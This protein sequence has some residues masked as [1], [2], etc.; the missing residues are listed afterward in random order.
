MDNFSYC[1]LSAPIESAIP[2]FAGQ[3]ANSS[4]CAVDRLDAGYVSPFEIKQNTALRNRTANVESTTPFLSN[5]QP[6]YR[7]LQIKEGDQFCIF[8]ANHEFKSNR[9]AIGLISGYTFSNYFWFVHS[10]LMG[11]IEHVELS[12]LQMRRVLRS[13][14]LHTNEK[15]TRLK[16]QEYGKPMPWENTQLYS[17][18]N[19][20]ERINPNILIEYMHR[21]FDIDYN[22][23]YLRNFR[24]VFEISAQNNG[25]NLSRFRKYRNIIDSTEKDLILGAL[26]LSDIHVE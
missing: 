5:T 24:R 19:L 25:M 2:W 9:A 7:L 3:F 20:D 6:A 26:K 11:R 12:V 22:S 17:R 4:L 21:V 8:E 18:P 16:F 13:V 10:S 1:I 14:Y 15:R 23:L